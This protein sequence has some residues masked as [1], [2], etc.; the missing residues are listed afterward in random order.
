MFTHLTQLETSIG[1][2]TILALG[3][4]VP[5]LVPSLAHHLIITC[6]QMPVLAS[7]R[8]PIALVLVR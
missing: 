6:P 2:W 3:A 7:T 1:D 5:S 8:C 4:L